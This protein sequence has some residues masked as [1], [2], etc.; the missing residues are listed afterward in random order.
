V[1][2][3]DAIEAHIE[4]QYEQYLSYDFIKD[5]EKTREYFLSEDYLGEGLGQFGIAQGVGSRVAKE[6]GELVSWGVFDNCREHGLTVRTAGGWTF[7]FYEH[8]NSDQ[9]CIE[10]CPSDEVKEWGP[11]GGEDKYDTLFYGRW[12]DYEV[13]AK[14]LIA[15]I[16]ASVTLPGITRKQ[17]MAIGAEARDAA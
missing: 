4:Q 8:R 9:I 7:C 16:E 3:A 17:L 1:R 2:F 15:M 12:L 10:G 13:A 11:Y 5:E 6:M 14:A